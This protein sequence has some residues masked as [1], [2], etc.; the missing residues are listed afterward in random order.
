VVVE[1]LTVT[2]FSQQEKPASVL[3]IYQTGKMM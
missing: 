2:I 3:F 1:A